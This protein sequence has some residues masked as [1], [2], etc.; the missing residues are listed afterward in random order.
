VSQAQAARLLTQASFGPNDA[1]IEAVR[2]AGIE[3]WITDQINAPRQ[4]ESHLAHMDR[5][6]AVLRQANANAMLGPAQ[7]YETWWKNAVSSNDQLRQRMT[8]AL[9]QVFVVSLNDGAIQ[10][11][12]IGSYY[13]MLGANAFANYRQLLEQVTLHPAMGIYLTYLGNQKEDASGARTPDENY[14]REVLQLMSIGLFELNPDGTVRTDSQ[15]RPLAA[16]TPDD[17]AGL[18]KVFTGFSWFHPAPS[19]TTFNGG[20]RDPNREVTPM[21]AYQN[22]HSTS[23]KTFLGR[24]IPAATTP[25]AQGDLR[26]ALDTIAAH[27]NVG[28]FM[29]TRLIQQLIESNPSRA[30]VQRCSGVWANNG[31]GVRGDL[32]A[33]VRAILTDAEARPAAPVSDDGKLREP[34]IRTTN[35]LRA[36]EARSQTGDWLIPSTSSNQSLAQAPMAAP[37]VFNFWRPGFVPAGTTETGRRNLLAPEFQAVDEVSVAGYTNTMANWISAGVG[38][39]PAGSST[40]DVTT[41]YTKE[42][43]VADNAGALVDRLNLLLFYGQMP[44]TLR[45]RLIAA[46]NSTPLPAAGATQATIDAVR[47]NRV[48]NAITIAMASPDYLVQR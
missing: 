16:Y 19:N 37:S 22:F 36:F 11:R 43:A 47:L 44:A 20:N 33:V 5:R 24:T 28:P 7:F 30:A 35:W 41:A 26:I 32:A 14:A 18:A 8:F 17:I 27:P 13:D 21:I 15:G 48:R 4:I 12:S 10:P 25:D 34:V 3:R 6:L 40:R 38:A 31:S 39:T 23:A 2:S 42:L 29:C 1:S 45:E 9:S 46:V